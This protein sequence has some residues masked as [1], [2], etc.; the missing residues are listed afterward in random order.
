[1]I[2]LEKFGYV[3]K[4]ADGHVEVVFSTGDPTEGLDNVVNVETLGFAGLVF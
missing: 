4:F 2:V 3:L 1:M